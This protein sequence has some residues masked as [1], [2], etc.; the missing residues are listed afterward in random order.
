MFNPIDKKILLALTDAAKEL[1]GEDD[2][3]TKFL[4]SCISKGTEGL[5]IQDRLLQLTDIDRDKLLSTAHQKLVLGPSA[6]LGIWEPEN[7]TVH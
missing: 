4:E 5:E 7:D 1:F 6:Y 2:E 3:C